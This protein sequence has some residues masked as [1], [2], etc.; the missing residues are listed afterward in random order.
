MASITQLLG[1]W[2]AGS[3][4]ALDR[5]MERVHPELQK[6]AA[7]HMARER[8]PDHTLETAA[9]VNEVF[10]RL[11]KARQVTM[12]E[13]GRFFGIASR[14]MRQVLVD[15]ARR[16]LAEKRG[17]KDPVHRLDDEVV[18]FSVS[19]DP[20]LNVEILSLNK[21]LEKLA[22]HDARQVEIVDRRLCGMTYEEI[23][24]DLGISSATVKKYW[25]MARA[26]LYR[27]LTRK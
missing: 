7:R 2:N 16:R 13:R 4:D 26:W 22:T 18:K 8:R 27:E 14:L 9:L 5:L 15:H 10:L 17:G 1:D 20:N 25:R 23:A 6:E 12:D 11:V 19:L 24:R 3:T 21:A